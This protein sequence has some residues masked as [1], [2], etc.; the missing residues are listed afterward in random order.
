VSRLPD[1]F[2]DATSS[3]LGELGDHGGAR[4]LQRVMEVI[5]ESDMA[6]RL[7]YMRP[8]KQEPEKPPGTWCIPFE[9]GANEKGTRISVVLARTIAAQL[10]CAVA[11]AEKRDIRQAF[12]REQERSASIVRQYTE[13]SDER[14]LLRS[15]VATLERKLRDARR[16]KRK[17]KR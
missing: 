15:Q 2:Y 1:A 5:S 13:A 17:A 11:E 8:L 14:F 12:E 9:Y 10:L 4:H 3:A 16:K 6:S 7:D